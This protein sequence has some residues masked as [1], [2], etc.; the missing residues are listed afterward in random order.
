[1]ARSMATILAMTLFFVENHFKKQ[2]TNRWH[3]NKSQWMDLCTRASMFI[4][5]KNLNMLSLTSS[6]NDALWKPIVFCPKRQARNL[7]E[8]MKKNQLTKESQ[9]TADGAQ[10]TL[11]L[12][13]YL[14]FVLRWMLCIFVFIVRNGISH[15]RE[16]IITAEWQL[17]AVQDK[18]CMLTHDHNLMSPHHLLLVAKCA[19]VTNWREGNA[20]NPPSA[21]GQKMSC[22]QQRM[23][24][25][26]TQTQLA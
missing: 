23:T 12:K 10:K 16:N 22:Q 7:M 3:N 4:I 11:T 25:I 20:Q 1:M 9:M 26:E 21:S 2:K 5:N 19:Q 15:K 13:F 18:W 24:L 8:S 14:L 6:N 17:T